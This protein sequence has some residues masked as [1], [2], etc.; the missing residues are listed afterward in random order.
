MCKC[1]DCKEVF[2]VSEVVTIREYRGEFWGAP[3]YET[4]G[5][6]P[7]CRSDDIDWDYVDEDEEEYDDEV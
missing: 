6:C 7:W 2:D 1:M 5:V 3:A 4:I